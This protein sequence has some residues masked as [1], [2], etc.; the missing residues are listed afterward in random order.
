MY[1]FQSVSGMSRTGC[2]MA[3]SNTARDR[4]ISPTVPSNAANCAQAPQLLGKASRN[5]LPRHTPFGPN[6]RE[7][8][9]VISSRS[10]RAGCKH[11]LESR[12]TQKQAAWSRYRALYVTAQSQDPTRIQHELLDYSMKA[13]NNHNFHPRV[14]C[15]RLLLKA[16]LYI[17][18]G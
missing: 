8:R 2:R 13:T 9:K 17:L 12:L 7:S 5:L 1:A 11:G 14:R 3:S 6:D 15:F 16:R 4:S 18:R 10:P